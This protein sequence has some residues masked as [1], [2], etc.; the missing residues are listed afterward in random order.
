MRLHD[1][2]PLG[3]SSGDFS[4]ESGKKLTDQHFDIAYNAVKKEELTSL[5][6]KIN[7]TLSKDFLCFYDELTVLL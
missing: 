4:T 6:K 5:A 3:E 7:S 2:K 1:V